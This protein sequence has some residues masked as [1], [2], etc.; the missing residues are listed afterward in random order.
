MGIPCC[1]YSSYTCLTFPRTLIQV[2]QASK[3]FY[4]IQSTKPI[5]NIGDLSCQHHT[6]YE[7]GK[8][9]ARMRMRKKWMSGVLTMALSTVL[10]LSGCSS[11]ESGENTPAPAEGT[12]PPTETVAQDTMIMG[13]G[14]DSVALDPAI[15]T[16]GESLKIGHQ[17]FDS[18]LDYKEGGTEVVP[19]LAESWEISADGLKYVFKLK[20]GVKFHDGTDLNAEA[21]V[22]NFNR[23]GDPASEYKFEGDSFDYYDSMFGP[24]DGRVIKEVKATD[25]TTVEF[26]LNQ[27]QAPFLQ[28]IAMT[29][30]GIASPTAIQEK[31]KTLRVSLWA[32]AHLYSKS[33]SVTTPSPWRKTRII[34]KKDCQS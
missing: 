32:P 1:F 4:M 24:E 25:E 30:F 34:G 6:H 7:T 23:W 33:G 27:P 3:A 18:L 11:N 17:V 2:S 5:A 29:P 13:R 9:V 10:V 28:N 19:G 8:G 26:T 22:F 15:V 20:S 16:D 14:G 21:V 12:D 31:K